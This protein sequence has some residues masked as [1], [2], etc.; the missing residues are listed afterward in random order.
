MYA[1]F[2]A[3]T[4]APAIIARWEADPTAGILMPVNIQLSKI[5]NAGAFRNQ[6]SAIRFGPDG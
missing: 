2:F 4:C 5:E 1:T 3:L 6:H